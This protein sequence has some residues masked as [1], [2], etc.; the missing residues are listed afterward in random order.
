LDTSAIIAKPHQKPANAFQNN[1]LRGAGDQ[2][3]I[4]KSGDRFS[5]KIMLKD[6]RAGSPR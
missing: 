1:A 4:R 3:M 2:S 6:Y 5:E